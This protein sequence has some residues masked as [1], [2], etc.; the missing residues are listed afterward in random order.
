MVGVPVLFWVCDSACVPFVWVMAV[1][2]GVSGFWWCVFQWCVAVVLA[3]RRVP[4]VPECLGVVGWVVS[5][6][7]VVFVWLCVCGVVCVGVC[8]G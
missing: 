2:V 4:G 3:S 7:S 6:V 8:V 1:G 5:C